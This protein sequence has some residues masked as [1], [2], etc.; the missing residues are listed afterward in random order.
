MSISNLPVIIP[1]KR[2]WNHGRIIGLNRP[3]FTGE[4]FVQILGHFIKGI[5]ICIERL[6]CFLWRDMDAS[7]A[8]I[9]KQRYLGT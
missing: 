7:F 2:A 4:C 9:V 8:A 5:Q 6:L 3:G 1:S